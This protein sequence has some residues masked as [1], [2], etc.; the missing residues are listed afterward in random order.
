MKRTLA[1]Y[2]WMELFVVN[3]ERWLVCRVD[4]GFRVLVIF[5]FILSASYHW[6]IQEAN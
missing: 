2:F 1:F 6:F 3:R 4:G 5:Y